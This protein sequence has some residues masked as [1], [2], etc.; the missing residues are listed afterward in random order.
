MAVTLVTTAGHSG[1]NAYGVA[2]V[3]PISNL[4]RQE[5]NNYRLVEVDR[6]VIHDR[7]L[8]VD[9]QVFTLGPGVDRAGMA[10]TNFGPADSSSTAHG[11][12]DDI[13]AKGTVIHS[14]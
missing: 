14:S 11:H 12:F 13:I 6:N 3:A 4:V 9:D 1:P 5:F 7:N 10:L 8:R 2:A